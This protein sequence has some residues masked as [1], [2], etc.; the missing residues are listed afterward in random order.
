MLVTGDLTTTALE[1]EFLDARAA[2]APLLADHERGT[3]IPGNH[4]RYTTEAVR[5]R[6][7]E[8]FFRPWLGG[9]EF[10][11]LKW[12]DAETPI[13]GLDPT[14]SHLSA[15]GR[16]PDAQLERA[17]A[18]LPR[19]ARGYPRLIVA[20][21]YP[22]EAPPELAAQLRAKR[23]VNASMLTEW[24]RAIGP[25]LYCCGHVHSAWA[26]ES[27]LVPGQLSLN[28]GAPLM[29]ARDG[30][31]PPGFLQIDMSDEATTVTHHGWSGQDWAERVLGCWPT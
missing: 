23:L 29:Q 14:R 6:R 27:V 28:A 1:A 31:V 21:H 17:K 25:H 10:P 8:R 18:L 4:D 13:L 26:R 7:F 12:I 24:L 5:S 3:V 20:C 2:L 16:L 15:T 19:R 22:I 11:W 9:D 30:Q